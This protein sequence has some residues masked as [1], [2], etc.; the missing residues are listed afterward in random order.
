M[1]ATCSQSHHACR[2]PRARHMLTGY[3]DETDVM[4]SSILSANCLRAQGDDV[5]SAVS[6]CRRMYPSSRFTQY[7]GN[8]PF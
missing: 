4:T 5:R 7:H 1:T 6:G 2:R 3:P 8:D